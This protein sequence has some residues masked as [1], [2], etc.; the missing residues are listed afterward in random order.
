MNACFTLHSIRFALT[1]LFK[2]IHA[3]KKRLFGWPF[4]RL[5]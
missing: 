5:P 1:G 4:G 3:E 2:S